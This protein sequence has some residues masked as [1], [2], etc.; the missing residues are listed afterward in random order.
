MVVILDSVAL[1]PGGMLVLGNVG[2]DKKT[3]L[4]TYTCGHCNRCVVM[5]PDRVRPRHQCKSCGK[6]V[7]DLCGVQECNV[8]ERDVERAFRDKNGQPW[9]L[10]H[11]G[12]P[13][14][15][16][17]LPDGTERLVLRGDHN[18]TLTERTRYRRTEC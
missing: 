17:F 11:G 15:R 8:F 7:C 16:I 1:K 12:L 2:S 14:D 5:R 9:L 18:M 4:P 3:E 13:V 10:R 6:R